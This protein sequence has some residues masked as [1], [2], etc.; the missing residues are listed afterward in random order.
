MAV[1]LFPEMSKYD[2][3]DDRFLMIELSLRERRGGASGIL[4]GG[5]SAAVMVDVEL[6]DD[7]GECLGPVYGWMLNCWP[8]RTPHVVAHGRLW[9]V[10]YSGPAADLAS[11]PFHLSDNTV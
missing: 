6:W 7:R 4:D 8:V 9:V 2:D 10:T 11:P 5:D 3:T 1:S